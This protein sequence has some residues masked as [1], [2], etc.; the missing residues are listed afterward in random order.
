MI[1]ITE[2]KA[3]VD[4]TRGESK[5]LKFNITEAS[6]LQEQNR[7]KTHLIDRMVVRVHHKQSTLHPNTRN[8]AVGVA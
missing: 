2:A 5:V 6:K 8:A 4:T 1:A 7:D 3:Q